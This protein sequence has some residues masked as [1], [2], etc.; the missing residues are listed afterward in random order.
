MGKREWLFIWGAFF[1]F[2]TF[3]AGMQLSVPE[4]IG[5]DGWLHIKTAELI[6]EQG[7]LQAFPWTT[8]SILADRY[9]DIQALF[10]V[11]LIP[12]TAFG[13]IPGAKIASVIFAA[14]FFTVFYWLLRSKNSAYPFFWTALF[15]FSS[16]D[17]LYRLMELRAT[18]LALSLLLLTFYCLENKK[19]WQLGVITLIYTWLY[20]GAA[21]QWGVILVFVVL[22]SLFHFWFQKKSDISLPK[23]GWNGCIQY[24]L[25]LFPALGS[26][27]G[28]FAHPNFPK[29]I[30]L[31]FIQ[32]FKVNLLGN[33]YNLEWKAWPFFELLRNNWVI[34]VLLAIGAAYL[35]RTRK[36]TRAGSY[37]LLLT[38]IF[39][40]WMLKTRRMHEY[41]LSI[42]FLFASHQLAGLLASLKVKMRL[43]TPLAVLLLIVFGIFQLIALN[44]AIR[45]NHILP[46]YYEGAQWLSG[47]AKA[48]ELVFINGYTFNY[49]FFYNPQLRF[50]HGVDLTYADV[51]DHLK[52]ER[53][54]GMLQGKDPGYNAIK[55]DYK[56]DWVFVGKIKQDVELFKLISKYKE[57]FELAYEDESV[58]VLKFK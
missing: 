6:K 41:F 4:I 18:A 52:F 3:I 30:S 34:F 20:P 24:K 17:F 42:A 32:V 43:I 40:V 56:P 12:F 48:G 53:Y 54:I 23:T 8:E 15:A 22:D 29:N 9:A 13:L 14:V 28:F 21:I 57:D 55:M 44:T 31:F 11:I 1:F 10:H 38:M 39:F 51:K 37:Y 25:L 50:T 58:G 35:F 26:V 47:H 7:F 45:N 36:I 49:L 27:I 5:Y 33:L 46:W 2:A 19:F 16:V